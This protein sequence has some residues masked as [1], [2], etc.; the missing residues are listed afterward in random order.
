MAPNPFE[1]NSS[2]DRKFK[3]SKNLSFDEAFLDAQNQEREILDNERDHLNYRLLSFLVIL[4]LTVLLGRIFILQATQGHEYRALA[5]GNKLRVQYVIAP[6]GLLEDR[7]GKVIAS[8]TPSFEVV[9][10]PAD[11]PKDLQE[12]KTEL[13]S[14][15][16]ILG[17]NYD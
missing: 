2:L 9:V 4:C 11:L 14:V 10:V 16:E 1:V 6:R 5:E 8:N 3:P 7:S 13:S 17:K 12:F 15:S